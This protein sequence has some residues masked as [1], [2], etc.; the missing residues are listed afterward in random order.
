MGGALDWL[1]SDLEETRLVKAERCLCGIAMVRVQAHP[2]R[3]E[4]THPWLP[5]PF[6]QTH[7]ARQ[8]LWC[9]AQCDLLHLRQPVPRADQVGGP[10]SDN[11][12]GSHRVSGRDPGQDGR[13]CDP[14]AFY[15]V[16]PELVVDDRHAVATHFSRAGLMP[17]RHR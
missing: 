10:L 5:E 1:F 17:V 3:L 14:E 8:G 13:V 7:P 6:A 16:N 15:S 12:A 9:S 2:L 11:H 4:A